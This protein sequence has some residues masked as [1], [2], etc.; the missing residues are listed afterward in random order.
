MFLSVFELFK[1]GIGPS[2]SHTMGPMT[3]ANRFLAE[4]LSNNWPKPVNTS[5]T[6]L[7][8]SLH[9]SL[10][11]TGLGH[12]TDRAVILG[13]LGQQPAS[14]DPDDMDKLV[15]SVY[16]TKK[17]Q[18]AGHPAYHF[19]PEKDLIF[20]R[21]TVLPGHSNGLVFEGLDQFGNVLLRRVYYS[22][23]G[24][25]V[26]SED[27]LNRVEHN[28]KND[29]R[30]VPFPFDTATMMLD[31]AKKSGLSI[32]E[33]KRANEETL[34][35]QN[36]LDEGLDKIF[37]AMKSSVDRGLHH[38]GELPGGL[39]IKRRAKKLYDKLLNDS[40]RNHVGPLAANDWLSTYA[41]AVNEEN[42]AGGRIVTAPTNG[43]AGVVPAVLSYYLR[44]CAGA[45][46]DGIRNFLLT[47]AAIGG[48]IKYNASI[49]GAEVGCQGE[50][51]SAASMAAAG[52]TAALGGTAMQIEN[53][54]EIALEHHLGM[55][56]D[57]VAGLVQVPCI[58]RNAMGA[59]K[60]V[61]A[62]SLALHGDGSHFVSL[63][64]CIRT[65]R[66]TG[67][68]MS[69]KYKETSKGGLAVNVTDC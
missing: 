43:A 50:V 15:A 28:K 65:M 9:G 52:L 46:R 23:G 29:N 49:S 17:V 66:E 44:F 32:A 18:P 40:K 22:I 48:V 37:L 42:A 25:F 16:Q 60:A 5:I 12:A 41:I 57:P 27:E 20:D 30:I 56:C 3:A 26:V 67:R 55:T 6:H 54:A 7:R 69:D 64:A 47:A 53:A 21:K 63:D 39:H 4:I 45:E 24:G 68:D 58:E 19:D 62:A 36:E 14:V 51:G 59:V 11:F 2:S 1:I 8:V 34:M 13:L 35:T 33:M 10:A 61:T 38:D 31:M